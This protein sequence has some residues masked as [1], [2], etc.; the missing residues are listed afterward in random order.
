[1]A[2]GATATIRVRGRAVKVGTSANLAVVTSQT[3]DDTPRND[4]CCTRSTPRHPS[5]VRVVRVR[6][7]IAKRASRGTVPAGGLVRF[8]ITVRN[9][10]KVSLRSVRVCDD[11]PAG[12]SLV[13]VPRGA[14]LR[15][16]RVCWTIR[17]LKPGARRHFSLL[18]RAGT[19]VSA[20]TLRNL[21][22]VSGPQ[23]RTRRTTASVRV[24][25]RRSRPGGVTG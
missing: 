11:L 5:T 18:A 12:L 1:M 7:P 20:R 23:I 21:A 13:R 25:G 16:G 22:L 9:P 19:P 3:P 15:S 6:V 24:P 17:R 2:D 4:R 10:T 8:G 14:A